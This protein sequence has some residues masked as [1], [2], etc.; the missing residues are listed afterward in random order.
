MQKRFSITIFLTSF[1]VFVQ[2]YADNFAPEVLVPAPWC[3]GPLI[4]YNGVTAPPGTAN[5]QTFFI[6]NKIFSPVN[7]YSQS[8]QLDITVG[9]GQRFD[10]EVIGTY[11]FNSNSANNKRYNGFEDVD[12]LLTFQALKAQDQ[13]WWPALRVAVLETFPAGKYD[14]L[15]QGQ[16]QADITGQGVY[17]TGLGAFFTK[18]YPLKANH[19]LNTYLTLIYSLPASAHVSGFNSYGGSAE[20]DGTE[21]NGGSFFADFALELSLSKHWVLANDISYTYDM[22]DNYHGAHGVSQ[23]GA[24]SDDSMPA[25]QVVSLAPALEYNFNANL[26]IIA[27]AWFSIYEKNLNKF[28]AGI[29]SL[30]YFTG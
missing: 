1:L 25:M 8:P 27:G 19:W 2:S 17:Q 30:N 13:A 4:A 12:A 6:S 10:L 3:T 11:T 20:T 7:L 9:L 28:V 15:D 16:L 18:Y 14:Q 24:S 23:Q 29:I 26:G 22:S 21:E 5:I